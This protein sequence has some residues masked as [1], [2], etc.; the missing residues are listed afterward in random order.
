MRKGSASLCGANHQVGVHSAVSARLAAYSAA[1]AESAS[2]HTN[3][4]WFACPTHTSS[5]RTFTQTPELS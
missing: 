4:R 5:L 3:S 1:P 2:A